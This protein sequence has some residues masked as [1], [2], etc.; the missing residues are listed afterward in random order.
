MRLRVLGVLLFVLSACA[1]TEPQ[2]QGQITAPWVAP[3]VGPRPVALPVPVGL[4]PPVP[5]MVEPDAPEQPDPEAAPKQNRSGSNRS[6]PAPPTSASRPECIPHIK[7]HLGGDALHNQCADK[8]P[9]NG[10]VGFDVLV[11]GKHFDALQTP[12]KVL[13][14][15]KTDNFDAYTDALK[16]IVVRKQVVELLHEREIARA[17][18][19]KFWVGVRSAA[20]RAALI[21]AD[22]SLDVAVMNWC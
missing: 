16:K 4:A 13:W 1:T 12:A 22:P 10:F 14:E 21:E 11:N 8:V 19:F 3:L 9:G 17:C 7:P 6:P 20:H 2:P 5:V 18:G 15:I